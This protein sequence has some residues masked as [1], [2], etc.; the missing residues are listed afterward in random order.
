MAIIGSQALIRIIPRT[1]YDLSA[2]TGGLIRLPVA[3]HIDV[4]GYARASLQVRV[5]RG[6][7][8]SG[9]SVAVQLADDGSDPADPSV[10]FL[11]TTTS[12]GADIGSVT[13][14]KQTAFPFYQSIFADVPASISRLAAVLLSIKG[15][16]EAG[17]VLDIGLDLVLSGGS[18]GATVSQPSTYLGYAHEPVERLE[19][20]APVGDDEPGSSGRGIAG[21]EDFQRR[22][23]DAVRGVLR[24]A[25]DEGGYPRFGNVNVAIA[26]PVERV[27]EPELLDIARALILRG[28]LDLETPDG[29]YARF[30]NVNVGIGR[31]RR[32]AELEEGGPQEPA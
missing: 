20:F 19:T 12:A 22:V 32:V 15:G 6:R 14:N 3:Q 13:L 5:Y 21:D 31:Q 30:G 18:V 27:A 8:P 2:L 11:Q 17:P 26:R 9:A 7:I 1:T 23:A 16:A 10:T 24:T 25:R 28:G 29:G 4:L